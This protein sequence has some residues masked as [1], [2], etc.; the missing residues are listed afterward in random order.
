[1][2][3]QEKFFGFLAIRKAED[4]ELPSFAFGRRETVEDAKRIWGGDDSSEEA[5]EAQGSVE[6]DEQEAD[7]SHDST[8]TEAL[9]RS[10]DFGLEQFQLI[11]TS[12]IFP[13]LFKN[14]VARE[15]VLNPTKKGGVKVDEDENTEIY[16]LNEADYLE[17][18]QK[19]GRYEKMKAGLSKVPSAIFL[20]LIASFDSLIVDILGKMLRLKKGW[21]EK[22]QRSL[23]LATLA[24]AENLDQ[25]I[26]EAVADE[27]YQFSRGSHDEQARY[28]EEQFGIG[29]RERWKRWPDYIE[30]FERRN[31]I[32]HGESTF[33][34]R[35]VSICSRSGHRGSEKLLGTDVE[36]RDSYLNQSLDILVEF[37]VL[38][39]FQLWRKGQ[40]TDEDEAF[41]NLSEAVYKLT[42]HGKYRA[43]ERIADFAIGLKGTNASDSV[44]RR[45]IVNRASALRHDEREEEAVA[46]L[47]TVDW[48]ASSNVFR[49]CVAAVKVDKEAFLALLPKVKNSD[50][51]RARSFVDWPVFEFVRSDEDVRTAL[52]ENFGEKAITTVRKAAKGE[53]EPVSI[54]KPDADKPEDI[55][56]L[57]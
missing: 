23:P 55:E 38:L 34:K 19:T 47:D 27:I 43:A 33:N 6:P 53:G 46:L 26:E 44:M 9:A 8:L 32:A 28:I 48:S 2:T 22:S 56:S 15:T 17:L 40:D 1:M 3:D 16:G 37:A 57:H 25:L 10:V 21:L 14:I 54:E 4:H 36:L 5:D 39:S 49:I 7:F 11:A 24:T 45:L 18:V 12:S 51:I 31:L 20:G 29:I 13:I 52:V 30:I 35:Y 42:E 41:T 50:E